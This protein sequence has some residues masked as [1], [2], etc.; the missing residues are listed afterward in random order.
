MS[1]VDWLEKGKRTCEKRARNKVM[2]NVVIGAA[3][4]VTAGVAAGIL[5]APKSGAEARKDI[6]AAVTEFPGK[7][8]D[9]LTTSRVKMEGF[10]GRLKDTKAKRAEETSQA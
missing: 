4:G 9:I 7:A 3:V 8:R 10:K 2:R 6:A 5:L 1:I